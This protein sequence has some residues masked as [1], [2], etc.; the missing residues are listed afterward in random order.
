MHDGEVKA[1]QARDFESIENAFCAVSILV[2]IEV[3]DKKAFFKCYMLHG[4]N[5]NSCEARYRYLLI[6][7]RCIES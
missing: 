5:V 7:S 6:I 2:R 4:M 1:R 3:G